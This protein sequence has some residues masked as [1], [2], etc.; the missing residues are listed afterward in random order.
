MDSGGQ[1]LVALVRTLR[2]IRVAADLSQQRLAK[3]LGVRQST[4]S[5]YE[6]GERQV[7]F[8]ELRRICGVLGLTLADFVALFEATLRDQAEDPK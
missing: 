5:K 8:I 2:R 7:G 6:S 4:I 1:E 3:A